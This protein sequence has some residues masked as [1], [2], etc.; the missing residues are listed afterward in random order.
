MAATVKLKNGFTSISLSLSFPLYLFYLSLSLFPF[1]SLSLSLSLFISFFL[2]LSLSF[3]C[4]SPSFL[5]D[6]SFFLI[7]Y[8]LSLYLNSLFLYL[9][10]SLFL[11]FFQSIFYPSNLCF[12]IFFFSLSLSF[13]INAATNDNG[14]RALVRKTENSTQTHRYE[15]NAYS[16]AISQLIVLH[17]KQIRQSWIIFSIKKSQVVLEEK[18]LFLLKQSCGRYY[19]H[20]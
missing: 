11:Y 7:T 5:S 3:T 18:S 4:L 16:Q 2:F 8:S 13:F 6:L 17:Y 15:K 19:I 1:L 10:L 12:V 14:T 20:T 9:S